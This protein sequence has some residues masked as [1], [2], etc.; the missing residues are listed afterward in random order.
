MYK[1][2]DEIPR[3]LRIALATHGAL[4]TIGFD[5]AYIFFGFT[6]PLPEQPTDH[7]RV[8]VHLRI[9]PLEFVIDVGST[10]KPDDTGALYESLLH[11]YNRLSEV[12]RR[13]LRREHYPDNGMSVL[14]HALLAKGFQLPELFDQ[15]LEN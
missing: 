5:P 9:D 10:P 7:V 6:R 11:V 15:E 2:L 12:E 8:T 3:A 1:N 4:S 14:I 13:A